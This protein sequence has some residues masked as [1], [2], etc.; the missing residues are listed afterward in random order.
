[1]WYLLYRHSVDDATPHRRYDLPLVYNR[2]KSTTNSYILRTDYLSQDWSFRSLRG[3]VEPSMNSQIRLATRA[4]QES[5]ISSMGILYEPY[6]HHEGPIICDQSIILQ[7][8]KSNISGYNY[9]VP[10]RF[11]KF[12]FLCQTQLA[13]R[14]QNSKT[15]FSEILQ[16]INRSYIKWKSLS[17]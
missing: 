10:H 2:T 8:L 11:Y 9:K 12:T 1:M 7:S 3:R 16:K 15:W 14:S 13:T 4:F 5:Q 6:E 17:G